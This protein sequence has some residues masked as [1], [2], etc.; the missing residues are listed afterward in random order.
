MTFQP[1]TTTK[2]DYLASTFLNNTNSMKLPKTKQSILRI[3]N[4]NNKNKDFVQ[5]V[6]T[7]IYIFNHVSLKLENRDHINSIESSKHKVWIQ[8][9]TK[10]GV[11]FHSVQSRITKENHLSSTVQNNTNS[12]KSPKTKLWILLITKTNHKK[13]DFLL[14]L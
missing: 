13:K 11:S 3:T 5:S 4:T 1:R 8:P 6:T 14:N 2:E 10:T 12:M 9:I 7:C